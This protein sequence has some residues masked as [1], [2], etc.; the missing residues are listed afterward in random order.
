M[1]KNAQEGALWAFL[2][3]S[4]LRKIKIL[5]EGTLWQHCRLPLDGVVHLDGG[6]DAADGEEDAHGGDAGDGARQG[7]RG[8]PLLG[9]Q[10][11]LHALHDHRLTRVRL[12][13]QRVP[14]H[15]VQQKLNQTNTTE[16]SIKTAL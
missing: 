2:S 10:V 15:C 5:K 12:A 8:A 11:P 1:P 16:A 14:T 7:G 9:P 3:S 6:V 13:D 4:W